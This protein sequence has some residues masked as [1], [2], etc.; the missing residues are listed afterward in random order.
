VAKEPVP[1]A[2]CIISVDRKLHCFQD[3]RGWHIVGVPDVVQASVS[4]GDGD[5]GGGCAVQRTG[6]V[7]CWGGMNDTGVFGNGQRGPGDEA[8]VIGVSDAIAVARTP[9]HACALT[10]SHTVWCWGSADQYAFG[11]AALASSTSFASCPDDKPSGPDCVAADFAGLSRNH[12]HLR[13]IQ[14]PELA[15]ITSIAAG[16]GI[17]CGTRTD[18]RILCVGDGHPGAFTVDVGEK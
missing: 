7:Y 16:V 15:G 11:D 1:D 3:G 17:T 13:A 4:G 18:G 14:V 10:K 12:L 8:D 6:K 2:P 5:A 9:D